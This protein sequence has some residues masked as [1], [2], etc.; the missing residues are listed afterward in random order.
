MAAR[1]AQMEASPD[2]TFPRP[3]L[4]PVIGLNLEAAEVAEA[5]KRLNWDAETLTPLPAVKDLLVNANFT[6]HQPGSTN[7]A[8][9]SSSVSE[10]LS[11]AISELGLKEA[12]EMKAVYRQWEE[13]RVEELDKQVQRFKE[14]QLLLQH[15]EKKKELRERQDTIFFFDNEEEWMMK[16]EE[17]EAALA[18]GVLSEEQSR[19]PSDGKKVK[20][21][22]EDDSDYV[23]PL[24]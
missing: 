22:K 11:K 3:Q 8:S 19:L 9:L 13:V 18:E 6:I 2:K 23:S 4:R 20:K 16:L 17:K 5:F 7:S 21:G 24:V 15:Q 14:I 12:E 10:Q 1:F